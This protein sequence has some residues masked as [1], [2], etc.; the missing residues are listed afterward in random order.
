MA[1]TVFAV[2]V[3]ISFKI[4]NDF[5]AVVQNSTTMPATAQTASATLTGQFPGVIDNTFLFFAMGLGVVT[6]ILAALVRVHPIFIPL[7]IIGLVFLIFFS[8]I[9]SN[10]YQEMAL[11]DSLAPQAAQLTFITNVM[12][13]LPFIIGVLG[14]LLM[15]VM[16]KLFAIEQ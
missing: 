3:L 15:I 6:L 4:T 14:V 10:V 7:F 8:A 9:Y 16:H 13:F 2:V 1:L 11:T 5:N 12:T